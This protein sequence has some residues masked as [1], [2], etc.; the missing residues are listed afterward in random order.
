M[1]AMTSTMLTHSWL[2]FND[3]PLFTMRILHPPTQNTSLYTTGDWSFWIEKV[4][5]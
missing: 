4:E 5:I 1:H 2:K 3:M